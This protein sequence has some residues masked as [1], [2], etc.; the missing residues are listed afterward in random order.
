MLC[1]Q[2][3]LQIGGPSQP[4]ISV[5]LEVDGCIV[6]CQCRLL[7][8]WVYEL[9]AVLAQLKFPTEA[10]DLNCTEWA[11]RSDNYYC[12]NSAS[13][14]SVLPRP[15]RLWLVGGGVLRLESR[16]ALVPGWLG[17]RLVQRADHLAE[18]ERGGAVGERGEGL[19]ASPQ[20]DPV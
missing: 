2:S 5:R 9:Y 4:G 8:C 1:S 7:C 10:D 18:Q 11:A 15:L 16:L 17:L 3:A 12:Q 13:I 14:L 20:W 19:L 6:N